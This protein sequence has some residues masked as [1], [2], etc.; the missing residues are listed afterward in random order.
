MRQKVPLPNNI[1]VIEAQLPANTSDF[2][3]EVE[4]DDDHKKGMFE[5]IARYGA[6][7]LQFVDNIFDA[8]SS[9]LALSIASKNQGNILPILGI[10]ILFMMDILIFV[11]IDAPGKLQN[12]GKYADDLCRNEAKPELNYPRFSR[13]EKAINLLPQLMLHIIASVAACELA[14]TNYHTLIALADKGNNQGTRPS[15]LSNEILFEVAIAAACFALATSFINTNS[16]A[17]EAAK[18]FSGSLPLLSKRR[19]SEPDNNYAVIEVSP[20]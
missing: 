9:F 7:P 3:M 4:C 6:Y 13:K 8:F 10:I 2:V 11:G 17:H 18:R 12:I 16:V 20:K 15:W 1:T 5:I 14:I 19:I